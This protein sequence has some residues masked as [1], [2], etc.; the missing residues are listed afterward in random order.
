MNVERLAIEGVLLLTPRRFGDERG[1][2]EETYNAETLR[3]AAGL[4]AQFVQ[5]NQSLSRAAGTVRGLHFQ[6]PPHAQAKLVR[7]ARGAIFDVAVDLRSAS[8]TFGRWVGAELSDE[9]G[10]QLFVPRG[11]AHGFATLTP[12]TLV[13][14]K[15]DAFYSREAD[16]GVRYDDSDIAIDWHLPAGEAT[17][18]QRDRELPR[19]SS[20]D[21]IF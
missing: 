7:V 18:S 15:V 2:F 21:A 17:L 13:C 4:D 10:A 1:Y 20:L 14:Y 11:F 19:L 16:G 6:T 9:N 3:D 12:D 5:D 8:P